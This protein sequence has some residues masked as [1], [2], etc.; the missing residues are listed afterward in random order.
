MID[1]LVRYGVAIH[2]ALM[3]V[4]SSWARGGSSPYYAWALP[5]LALGIVEMMLLMP[6]RNKEDSPR[7]AVRRMV[8]AVFVDP[9]TYIGLFLLAFL[10]IQWLNGPCELKFDHASQMWEYTDPPVANLPFCVDRGE[11]LH[12][13][14]WFVGIVAAVIAVRHG[15]K[16]AGRIALLRMLV[17]NGALLSLLGIAQALT[18]SSGPGVPGVLFWYRQMP[19]YFFSTFGYPN[20]AGTFFVMLTAINIGLLIHAIAERDG[21]D[22]G[23]HWLGFSL[24]LNAAGIYFSLCRAAMVLGTLVIVVGGLY[25]AL[26]LHKTMTKGERISFACFFVIFLLGVAG[27]LALPGSP[28]LKEVKTIDVA[29]LANV[30]VGDRQKLVDSAV[31][32]WMD[33]PWTGVGGWGFRRFVGLYL[34]PEEWDYLLSAGRAN[35]HNDA[36]QFLCEHGAIGFGLMCALVISLLAHFLFRLGQ[37]ER[38]VSELGTP[39]TWFGSISPVSLS[40]LAAVAAMAVH[41]TIDLPFRSVATTLVWFIALSCTP[42][43]I[44]KRKAKPKNLVALPPPQPRHHHHHHDSE[45]GDGERRGHH[46]HHHDVARTKF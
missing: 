26:Y 34:S 36:V 31:S 5:W 46:D 15:M 30:Y 37:M 4:F 2:V 11:A 29:H 19:V 43:L 23:R 20:H 1:L 28:L 22:K 18:S 8:R 7:G 24:V 12:V 9:V 6:P 40:C 25:G 38:K 14:L 41:S 3:V 16:N 33:Y 17:A 45:G 10:V 35:V 44:P 32:I 13:L 27:A 21:A 42:Y 39:S